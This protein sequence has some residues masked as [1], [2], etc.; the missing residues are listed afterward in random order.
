MTERA[1]RKVAEIVRAG[2]FTMAF[3]FD[4]ERAYVTLQGQPHIVEDVA[5]KR[6]VWSPES[7]RFHP[8]GPEDPNVVIV[9]LRVDRIELYNVERGV[10]PDPIGLCSM[11]LERSADGWSQHLT[12][13][14]DAA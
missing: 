12:S 13:P 6:A 1:C 10:Q 14:R 9:R 8:G 3:Q 7:Q 5:V 11:V 4:P 2:R